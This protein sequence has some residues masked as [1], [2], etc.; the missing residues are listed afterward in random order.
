MTFVVIMRSYRIRKPF[1]ENISQ[2]FQGLELYFLKKKK[3]KVY[4]ILF[5][6]EGQYFL[7]LKGFLLFLLKQLKQVES[8]SYLITI[9]WR[10]S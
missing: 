6:P 8:V 10:L 3:K 2:L 4:S 5:L 1:S 9:P 7:V